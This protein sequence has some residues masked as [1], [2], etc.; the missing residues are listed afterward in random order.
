MS[1]TPPV[2]QA[3]LADHR[4]IGVTGVPRQEGRQLVER[5][6]LAHSVEFDAVLLGGGAGRRKDPLCLGLGVRQVLAHDLGRQV[7]PAAQKRL[8]D[9]VQRGKV[10]VE[11]LRQDQRG[12]QWGGSRGLVQVDQEVLE[13]HRRYS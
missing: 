12:L 8:G 5:A 11:S 10:R 4:E 13:C 1:S 3:R 7:T 6:A 2:F 9:Q